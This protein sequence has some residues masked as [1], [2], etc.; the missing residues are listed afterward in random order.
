MEGVANPARRE[1]AFAVGDKA[2]LSSSHLPVR[3]G[4]RK[5]SAKWA[6]PFPVTARIG[7]EAYRLKLPASWRIHDVF[8][9]SQLKPVVGQPQEEAAVQLEDGELEYE[10]ERVL[11]ER[12]VRGGRQFLVKW[13]GYGDWENSWEPERNLKNS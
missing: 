9:T 11:G 4:T 8:H 7:R 5:L 6:G 13:K 10:V 12:R 1:L 3:T 2:W